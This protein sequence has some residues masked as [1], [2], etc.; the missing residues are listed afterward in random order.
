MDLREAAA[1]LIRSINDI[2]HTFN[3]CDHAQVTFKMGRDQTRR[4]GGRWCLNKSLINDSLFKNKIEKIL[5]YAL[6]EC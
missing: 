1:G 3:V 6:E 2:Q 4:G 5:D